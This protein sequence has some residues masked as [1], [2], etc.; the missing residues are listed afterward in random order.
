MSVI[1]RAPD[2]PP[3]TSPN[4]ERYLDPR[5]LEAELKRTFQICH[6]CR[7]CVGYCGSFPELFARVDRDIESGVAEGAE[8]LT[9]DDFKAVGDECWQCK[10]CY[11]KCPYTADE[12]AYEL[13]DYP[14]VLARERAVRAQREGIPLV[15]R[16]LG[17]PQLI[18]ALGSGPAAPLANLVQAS[19]LLRKVQ[20]KVTGISA[21]FPLPEM[22]R[23]PFSSWF[24]E[25]SAAPD[26][27]KQGAVVLFAT[28]YGE[29]NTPAVPEAAVRVLE[30]NGYAVHVP[31]CTSA[32]E[33]QDAPAGALTCCGMPNLDGGDLEAFTAKVKQNVELLLPHVRMGRKIVVV[34]PTCGYTMKKEWPEYLQ[35]AAAREVAAAT[36]DMMEFL[37]Q[38]GREKKLNREF[39]KGLG[40]IAYHA[41]CHLRAQ[42]IGFPGARVLGVVPDTEVRVIE[43]C[44]AVDGTWGMKAEHYETG[45]KYASK[46]V[47]G[48][49]GAD[50]IVSDCT[51]AGLRMVK[52][53]GAKVLHP[54]EALVHAYGL[55]PT[56]YLGPKS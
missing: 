11:I 3:A 14:R 56:S 21:E 1:R 18:G 48:V 35:T 37:V 29:F 45:R 9:Y 34:G 44:S 55:G 43:Q 24:A 36:V 50:V 25:H 22:A 39:K 42:K 31:G 53:N 6:E 17:E 47:R 15:D 8:A 33:P 38:L 10:L 4:D 30:H 52:E 32:D 5:D 13:L 40:T 20:E 16:I 7:M 27:G 19:R 23:K 46:L 49:A 28:C 12:H 51:L 2:R 26:A 41:A 54:V